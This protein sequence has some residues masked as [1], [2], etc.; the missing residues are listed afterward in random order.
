MKYSNYLKHLK[1]NE[2][3]EEQRDLAE[4]IGLENYVKLLLK[5]GGNNLYIPKADKL[6]VPIRNK[7][8][9]DEFTGD[10]YRSLSYKYDLSENTIRQIITENNSDF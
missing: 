4:T 1:L 6:I 5:F 2:L 8:I 7:L 3:K 10:N 9:F